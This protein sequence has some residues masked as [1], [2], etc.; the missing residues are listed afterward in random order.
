MN[1]AG[2]VG[3]GGGWQTAVSDAITV[4]IIYGFS[5]PLRFLSPPAPRVQ[6]DGSLHLSR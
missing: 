4:L 5:L 1:G 2:G 3:G 6:V